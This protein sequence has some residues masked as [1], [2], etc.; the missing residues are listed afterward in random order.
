MVP[1]MKGIKKEGA[2]NRILCT[3]R[4]WTLTTNAQTANMPDNA[5]KIGDRRGKYVAMNATTPYKEK[6]TMDCM[7]L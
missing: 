7:V 1:N 2:E 6:S 4:N 3:A 5:L